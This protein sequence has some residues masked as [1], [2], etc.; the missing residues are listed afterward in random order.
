M[1]TGF[2]V[3]IN[4]MRECPSLTN[5]RENGILNG[6][7]EHGETPEP[8]SVRYGDTETNNH[9]PAGERSAYDRRE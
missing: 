9:P 5:P 2:R 3:E 7:T 4:R 1:I 6:N 8:Q